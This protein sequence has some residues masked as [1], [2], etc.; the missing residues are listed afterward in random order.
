MATYHVGRLI[1]HVHLNAY[2][3]GLVTAIMIPNHKHILDGEGPC[4]WI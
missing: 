3:A 4:I 2:R 1:D